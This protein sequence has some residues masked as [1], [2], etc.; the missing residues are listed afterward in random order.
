M[1]RTLTPTVDKKNKNK[2]AKYL[3]NKEFRHIAYKAKY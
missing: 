3:Q 1:S 2:K